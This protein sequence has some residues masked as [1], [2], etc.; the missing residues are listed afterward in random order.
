M[1]SHKTVY[2]YLEITRHQ[3]RNQALE[4]KQTGGWGTIINVTPD[5]FQVDP[6][7][8]SELQTFLTMIPGM[9]SMVWIWKF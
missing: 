2:L 8:P 4:R 1:S 7:T 6:V 3:R 9:Y 5:I